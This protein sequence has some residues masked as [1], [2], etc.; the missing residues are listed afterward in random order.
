VA[1]DGGGFL[2][3]QPKLFTRLGADGDEAFAAAR[4]GDAHHFAGGTRH[5]VG[6]VAGNVAKQRHLRQATALG[7]GGVAHGLQIAVVQML[8]PG[9]QHA[10]A[11][12]LGEHEVL[13]LDDAGHGVLG[14]AKEL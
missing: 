5:V 13:D 14:V 6:V 11:L 2:A 1:A 3:V 7:L 10:G 12:L 9:Q 4:I 8:Q